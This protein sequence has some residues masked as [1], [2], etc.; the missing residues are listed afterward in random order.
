MSGASNDAAFQRQCSTQQR[1]L[2]QFQLLFHRPPTRYDITT[3]P[4][5]DQAAPDLQYKLNMQRKLEILRYRKGSGGGGGGQSSKPTRAQL[6]AQA[7]RGVAQKIPQTR[8]QCPDGTPIPDP[9]TRPSL[10]TAAA[11]P[12]P[13]IQMQYDP[14]VPLYLYNTTHTYAVENTA[15]TQDWDFI[16]TPDVVGLNEVPLTTIGIKQNFEGTLATFSVTTS[17]AF[18]VR[19]YAVN[20]SSSSPATF[21]FHFSNAQEQLKLQFLYGTQ[22]LSFP[23]NQAP[24]YAFL[25]GF[26]NS[27]YGQVIFDA[28]DPGTPQYFEATIFLGNILVNNIVLSTAPGYLYVVQGNAY[29]AF[30]NSYVDTTVYPLEYGLIWNCQES[31]TNAIDGRIHSTPNLRLS[32][33]SPDFSIPGNVL[34]PPVETSASGT[35][36]GIAVTQSTFRATTA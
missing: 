10:S 27:L 8:V 24:R 17:V 18:F 15:D 33:T 28:A 9:K 13:P 25:D 32:S 20:A 12:G 4:Y 19:G 11:I 22:S 3:G 7:M 21:H 5:G 30:T 1:V 14:A 29:P 6:Y 34:Q 2:R 36:L 35:V 23:D 26:L 31:V 16:S